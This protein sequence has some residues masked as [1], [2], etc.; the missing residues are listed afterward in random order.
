MNPPAEGSDPL[1]LALARR[2]GELGAGERNLLVVAVAV[3]HLAALWGLLQISAVQEAVRQVA[4]I[5]VDF[6]TL[7]PPKPEPEPPP[8]PTPR[9]Q[10]RPRPLPPPVIA[11]PPAPVPEAPA[12]FVVP[13]PPPEPVP[14][15]VETA[16]PDLAD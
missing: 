8:P 16:P 12:A 15:P 3:A 4:P 14:I 11:A 5:V 10:P 1:S 6:I 13:P 9:P 7:E 2:G